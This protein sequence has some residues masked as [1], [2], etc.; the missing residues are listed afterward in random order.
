LK[1]TIGVAATTC[2]YKDWFDADLIVFLGANP[3]N[4]QPVTTKYLY[5]A[6]RRGAR[7]VSVN[8]YR[9]PGLE[10]YWIPSNADSALFGTKLCDRTFLVKVGGDL[11]FLNAVQKILVRD[12]EVASEFV[13]AATKGYEALVRELEGQPMESLLAACGLP[14]EEVEACAREI[15]AAERGVLVWSMG[16]TRAA[17]TRC[18]RS[19]T[20]RSCASGSADPARD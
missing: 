19:R 20:S 7:V 1:S 8:A 16:S 18:A 17:A 13:R 11:A 15:A 2:S 10:R 14:L 12:Q 5:E 4:D 3:A 6:R 9:E